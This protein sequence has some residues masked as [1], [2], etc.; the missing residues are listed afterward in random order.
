KMLRMREVQSHGR[1]ATGHVLRLEVVQGIDDQPTY[2]P[3]VEFQADNRKLEVKGWGSFPPLYQ[4]GQEV[5]VYY[6]PSCPEKAQ[7]VS[8]QAWLLAWCFL[9][10]GMAF[11][12]LGI[13]IAL[14]QR[15]AG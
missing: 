6:F 11:I 2:V 14:W 5:T 8:R 15:S 13:A 7:I 9:T 10:G 12:L 1:R 3:V 4:V